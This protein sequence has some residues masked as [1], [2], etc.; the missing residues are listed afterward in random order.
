MLHR[1]PNYYTN[2]KGTYSIPKLL[3]KHMHTHT[4][5]NV[6]AIPTHT[7]NEDSLL[8]ET[9]ACYKTVISIVNM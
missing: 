7:I 8:Y 9:R 3:K 4:K 5:A 6:Y 2:I 1:N